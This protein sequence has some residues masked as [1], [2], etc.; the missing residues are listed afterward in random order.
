MLPNIH[1]PNNPGQPIISGC[2][3]PTANLSVYLDYYRKPIVLTLPSYIKDTDDFL[4]TVLHPNIHI[5]AN[6]ILVT[7]DVQSLYTNIPQNEGIQACLSTLNSFYGTNLPLPFRYLEQ[8]FIYILKCNYF[9][10]D[11]QFYLQIHGTAMGTAF[12]PNYSNIYLRDLKTRLYKMPHPP[13][14]P[15]KKHTTI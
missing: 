4:Q 2:D 5:P 3:S 7:M 9:Q 10:F 1:K 14:P 15:K 8:M 13:P 12:A 11:K 6:A